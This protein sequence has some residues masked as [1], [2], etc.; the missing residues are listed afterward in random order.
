MFYL[1][2]C[3]SL[4]LHTSDARL[5]MLSLY[6]YID[7]KILTFKVFLTLNKY[8]D[9]KQ[10]PEELLNAL[11]FT[12]SSNKEGTPQQLANLRD[13]LNVLKNG[14]VEKCSIF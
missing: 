8:E 6:K 7:E 9:N 2:E 12:N 10:M 3:N 5:V 14:G 11:A 4:L 13:Y 1:S